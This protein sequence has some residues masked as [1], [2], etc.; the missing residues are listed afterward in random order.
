[1]I[2]MRCRKNIF[3]RHFIFPPDFL[4]SPKIQ[5]KMLMKYFVFFLV[6]VFFLLQAAYS[7]QYL[8]VQKNLAIKN[9][10]YQP[11]DKISLQTIRGD[12]EFDGRISKITDSTIVIDNLY[13]IDLRNIAAVFRKRGFIKRLSGLFFIRGGIAYTAITGING[14][15]NNDSPMID[16]QTLLISAAMV[17][18]GFA[19]KPLIIK[20]LKINEKWQLKVIDFYNVPTNG[21]IIWDSD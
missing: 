6:C 12:L 4:L 11:G 3:F 20:K 10:K 15:I 9:Y 18:I 19:M 17:A 1:M 2:L 7:Q 13:E 16:Q 5:Q 8:V 14:L 21:E